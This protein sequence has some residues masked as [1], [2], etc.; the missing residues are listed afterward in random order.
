MLK[1]L[2]AYQTVE[3]ESAKERRSK[4]EKWALEMWQTEWHQTDKGRELYRRCTEVGFDRLQLTLKAVQ[5]A[6]GHGNFGAYLQ[7]FRLGG[8][9]TVCRCGAQIETL[10]HILQIWPL[11]VRVTARQNFNR[12][13]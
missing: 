8:G 10:Q 3:A 11:N 13:D 2:T 9:S 12:Q 4:W 5:L 6:T 7:R 1:V